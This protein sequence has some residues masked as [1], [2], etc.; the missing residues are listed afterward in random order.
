MKDVTRNN[1][2][3]AEAKYLPTSAYKIRPVADL[4]RNKAYEQ[5]MAILEAMP[6]KGAFFLKKVLKSAAANAMDRNAKLDESVLV[7]KY[8]MV[9]EG[10]QQ[11]RLWARSHGKADRLLKRSS[12]IIVVVDEKGA[13]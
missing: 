1:G 9:N 5:A 8:V 6:Q 10:P 12:H 3:R 7:I 13:K 2:Y 4:I 11:K